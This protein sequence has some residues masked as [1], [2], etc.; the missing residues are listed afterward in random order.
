MYW[1]FIRLKSPAD[2]LG[3][4][5]EYY[6]MFKRHAPSL[7]ALK[8]YK[9]TRMKFKD[10]RDLSIAK[11]PYT[12]RSKIKN[13]LSRDKW[14]EFIER[15]QEYFTWLENTEKGKQTLSNL[16]AVPES[17]REAVVKGH[18]KTQACA[19]FNSGKG[20]YEILIEFIDKYGTISTTF[21]KPIDKAHLHILF[22]MAEYLDALLLNNGTQV[23]DRSFIEKDWNTPPQNN[24][25]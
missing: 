20:Y 21:I 11:E 25:A 9:L 8:F 19:E 12:N 4:F 18:F 7:S 15:N 17:F 16:E 6:C 14:I 23:I 24:F 13:K 1:S 2:A 10:I 22:N 3:F 5:I